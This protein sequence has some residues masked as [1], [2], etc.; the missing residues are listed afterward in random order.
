MRH[1]CI[2]SALF[3]IMELS[4]EPVEM[5]PKWP[6]GS[7]GDTEPRAPQGWGESKTLFSTGHFP[8][9]TGAG[10]REF[11]TNGS[12]LI[13]LRKLHAAASGL[14]GWGAETPLGRGPPGDVASRCWAPRTWPSP[15]APPGPLATAPQAVLRSPPFL[16][17]SNIVVT[18]ITVSLN[19]SGERHF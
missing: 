19:A 15:A 4:H 5:G 1:F 11:L 8:L 2:L 12:I 16:Q 14:C 13:Y 9:K 10:K 7:G 3:W 17:L 18:V 6:H